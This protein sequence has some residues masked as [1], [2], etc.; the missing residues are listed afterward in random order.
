MDAIEFHSRQAG[1]WENGYKTQTF[2]SRLEVLN[3]LI[4]A[5]ISGQFWLDAGC[6]TGTI[7]RWMADNRGV[8][9][10]ALDASRPMI[11]NATPH[12]SVRFNVGNVENLPLA[13]SACDG[14]VCSSVLEYFSDTRPVLSEFLRVLKPGGL[15]CLSVP[16]ANPLA[17]IPLRLIYW[18]TMPLGKRRMFTYLDHSKQ[19][20]TT[21]S[22]KA[23]LVNSGFSPG[24]IAAFGTITFYDHP[25]SPA[26]SLFMAL[27]AKP[28]S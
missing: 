17:R 4:P 2:G 3:A 26:P 23:L 18:M 12:P 6:G 10:T 16:N 13:D 28:A 25:V 9:V 7:A 21:K 27:A 15:L 5:N 20:Y 22:L 11:D 8:T 24:K 19:T 14:I 1:S